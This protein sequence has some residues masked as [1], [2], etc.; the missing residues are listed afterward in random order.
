MIDEAHL[1]RRIRELGQNLFETASRHRTSFFSRDR[2]DAAVMDWCMKD[3]QLKVQMFRFIDVLPVLNTAEDLVDHLQEYFAAP[4]RAF[5]IL[6]Q[7]GIGLAGGNR[8]VA[9]AAAATVRSNAERMAR[10]FIA[11]TNPPETL[12]VI[13]RLRRQKM[14]FTVDIL[15]EAVVSE[16]ESDAYQEQYLDLVDAL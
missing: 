4:G 14:A 6:G 5:P 8:L 3:P 11:G 10:R 15:G 7:W 2:W 1:E 12:E 13:R 9:K 16:T